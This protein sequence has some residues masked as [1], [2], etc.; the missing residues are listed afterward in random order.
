MHIQQSFLKPVLVEGYA[1]KCNC[2]I[3]IQADKKPENLPPRPPLHLSVVLD[4]SGSMQG[5][6]LEEAKLC[7]QYI[8]HALRAD[9]K[10]S[11]VSYDS[12]V[13]TNVPLQ[14]P[15]NKE[16]IIAKID[17]IFAGGM[18]NLHGGWEKGKLELLPDVSSTSLSRVLLLS[19][20]CA[21]EGITNVSKISSLVYK[22]MLQGVSTSTYGLGDGFNE[23]LMTEMA[24]NGGGN[25]YYGETAKDLQEPFMTEL[26][27]LNAISAKNV[28]VHIEAAEGCKVKVL[29]TKVREE[30]G[31]YQLSDIAFD[32]ES[33]LALEIEVPGTLSSGTGPRSLGTVQLKYIDV[34]QMQ[35]NPEISVDYTVMTGDISIETLPAAAF[36]VVLNDEWVSTRLRE[37]EASQLQ[38]DAGE[39]AKK[40]DWKKVRAILEKAKVLAQNNEWMESI[41]TELEQL[42]KA[43]NA[44]IFAKEAIYSSLQMQKRL[45]S[46]DFDES[47][48]HTENLK[49]SY[50]RR[51]SRQGRSSP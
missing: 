6:P 18:T 5:A 21:N 31:W 7:A 20:G 45:I 15:T 36:S 12:I 10:I 24:K 9:D 3:R 44:E 42:A 48:I 41:V 46:P 29:N 30:N 28:W 2:V 16:E 39:A 11:V 47:S 4:R 13:T 33:W 37:L 50:L 43:E 51:K 38:L 32:S 34:Q 26:D 22:A 27:L 35:A 25:N 49:P 19:D 23:T 8:V 14:P 40:G 1:Q 17:A